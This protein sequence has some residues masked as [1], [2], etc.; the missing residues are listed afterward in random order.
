VVRF[1]D[2]N[3]DYL[4]ERYGAFRK[5][6]VASGDGIFFQVLGAESLTSGASLEVTM[7]GEGQ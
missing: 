4:A 6:F 1:L 5:Q 2:V 7:A 3:K